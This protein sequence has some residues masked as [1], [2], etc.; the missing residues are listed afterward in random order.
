MIK[1]YLENWSI[2]YLDFKIGN[3]ICTQ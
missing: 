3:T 1:K 2:R